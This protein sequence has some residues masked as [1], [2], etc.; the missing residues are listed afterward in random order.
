MNHCTSSSSHTNCVDDY[1]PGGCVRVSREVAV[2]VSGRNIA[3]VLGRVGRVNFGGLVNRVGANL[4]GAIVL[5]VNRDVV[6]T[7]NVPVGRVVYI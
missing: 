6:R 4:L 5:S 1:A 7:A 2:V 3:D